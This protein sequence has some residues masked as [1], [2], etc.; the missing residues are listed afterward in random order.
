MAFESSIG[1]LNGHDQPGTNSESFQIFGNGS[2][3]T[4]TPAPE[5]VSATLM[6]LAGA[7]LIGYVAKRRKSNAGV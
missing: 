5:P 3:V 6:G 2:A 4:A 1:N 7:G